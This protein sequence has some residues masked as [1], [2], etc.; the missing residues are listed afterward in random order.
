MIKG[1]LTELEIM[2]AFSIERS[3]AGKPSF[4]NVRS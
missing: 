1:V 3:S 2:I 4:L